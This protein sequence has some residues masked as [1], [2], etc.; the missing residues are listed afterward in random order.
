MNNE[1][2]ESEP[3]TETVIQVSDFQQEQQKLPDPIN[4]IKAKAISEDPVIRRTS[5]DRLVSQFR[6]SVETKGFKRVEEENFTVT[7]NDEETL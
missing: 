5:L 2:E 1:K 3:N 6:E 4:N 7:M